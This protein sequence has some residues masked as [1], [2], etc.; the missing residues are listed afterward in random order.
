[1]LLGSTEWAEAHAAELT[2]HAVAYVNTDGNSRGVLQMEGSHTLEAL[3]NGVARDVT[4]PETRLSVLD[5]RRLHDLGEAGN[6]ENR[7]KIRERPDVRLE[8]LGSGTD[9]TTFVD[10]LG[11][12]SL[13]LGF[14]GEDDD[15]IYHSIY[16][17]FFWYSHFSDRDFVYGRA[18]AQ[19][20][21]TA[22]MRL[23]DADLL[24]FEFTALADAV[25]GYLKEVQKLA[26][27]QRDGIIE[28][29]K[30]LEEGVFAADNDPRRPMVSPAREEP[31][32]FL[33]FAPLANASEALTRAAR[34]YAAAQA[35]I[36]PD[37]IPP[38]TLRDWNERLRG[39][40]RRLTDEAGLPRRPWYKHMLYAPGVYTGYAAKTMPGVREAI[41]QKRF[42]EADA[43]VLR[44]AK[45]L[46]AETALVNTLAE[47]MERFGR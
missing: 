25:E 8:A 19:T 1:M 22:V 35:R 42:G 20:V 18:L 45:V 10:H 16:D 12:A 5:R 34:R 14:A 11:I 26:R 36:D 2:R 17:D 32:P 39:S 30:E 3:I 31:P 29:N 27:E 4:D 13:N 7:K 21:G 37:K 6:D 46:D 9:Y 28:R 15:G 23:A 38:A 44:T 33:N 40:E 43:E 24:P 47:E 41:E